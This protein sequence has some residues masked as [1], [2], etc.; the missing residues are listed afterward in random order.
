MCPE[1]NPEHQAKLIS[2]Q[3]TGSWDRRGT[4][5]EGGGRGNCDLAL[6]LDM[7]P[8]ALLGKKMEREKK[9][10]GVLAWL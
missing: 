6:L 7:H 1:L 8:T 10:V 4:G 2:E 5:C 9:G 3:N